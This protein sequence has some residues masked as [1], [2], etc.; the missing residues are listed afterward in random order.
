M[1]AQI[2]SKKVKGRD[3]LSTSEDRRLILK[4]FKRYKER[5]RESMEWINLIQD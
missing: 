5:E 3:K 4:Y 1:L 2:L